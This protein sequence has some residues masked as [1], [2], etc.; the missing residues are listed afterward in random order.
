MKVERLIIIGLSA[1]TLVA[2]GNGKQATT[3]STSSENNSSFSIENSNSVAAKPEYKIGDT[4]TFDDKAELTITGVDWTDERKLYE[5]EKVLK[6]TY[7]VKNLSDKKY[8][9]GYELS[10]Y[11]DNK[12]VDGYSIATGS[13]EG[14]PIGD[15]YEGASQTFVINNPGSI[16]LEI[17][18][19]FAHGT[20]P[21]VIKLDIQ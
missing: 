1:L 8:S 12:R 9:I 5:T 21:A 19:S 14:L 3:S 17:Q 15:T 6:V 11:V 7:N 10:C 20:T 18:P 16:E 13:G 4:I 2:C